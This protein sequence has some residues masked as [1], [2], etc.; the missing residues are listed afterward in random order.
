MLVK[1]LLEILG[2]LPFEELDAIPQ[3]ENNLIRLSSH[4]VVLPLVQ[5][6]YCVLYMYINTYIY[7]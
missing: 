5:N 6:M 1:T 3:H 2:V 7:I 4:V